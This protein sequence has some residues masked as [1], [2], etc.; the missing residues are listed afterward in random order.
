[1]AGLR[2]LRSRVVDASAEVRRRRRVPTLLVWCMS[3]TAYYLALALICHAILSTVWVE[4][5]VHDSSSG[6]LLHL[7]QDRGGPEE[8]LRGGPAERQSPVRSTTGQHRKPSAVVRGRQASSS[9]AED[10]G[11]HAKK[12]PSRVAFVVTLTSCSGH[13]GI[14]FEIVE[15]AA[16]LRYSIQQNV[17]HGDF[18]MY[19]FYH[20]EAAPCAEA[21]TEL[22]YVVQERDTPVAV[23]DIRGDILRE[24]I[25]KNGCCGEKELIK[26][27][28]FTL[29]Q[30]EVVVLLDL[31]VL[32]MK[33]MDKLFDF[34][35]DPK[36]TPDA[37]DLLLRS[38][39]QI[40][41]TID[42][43]YTTDY[44]MVKPGRKV[45][46]TQGG[47]VVLRPNRTVYDEFVEIIVEGDFRDSNGAGWGGKTGKFWGAMTFQ[48]LMPYYFQV[49]HPGRAV[50]LNW[51]VWNNMCS[52]SRDKGVENDQP[53]GECFTQQE[54]CEDC[55]NR[56][57]TDVALTHFTVC[58]KPW[59]CQRMSQDIINHRL[60]RHLHHA[61]FE[62]R[63][64]MERS[65]GR[66]GSGNGTYDRDHFN[67][68]CSLWG[69]QGYEAIKKPYGLPLSVA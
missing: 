59:T 5:Q 4:R 31:D 8:T 9:G 10:G 60:C 67:G 3:R 25:V 15:G 58:Q 18:T 62:T 26:L 27:E 53:V 63:S 49:L 52:P 23:E 51:C 24:R 28:A 37:D 41:E 29:T 64:A 35:L 30:H 33:S 68:Y 69:K 44:A 47:F 57:V 39:E 21:L 19:A 7:V 65:W 45:K 2:L 48:G 6:G 61:W 46:P 50:E 20:P 40:P 12:Q 14:P 11:D 43:L 34:I 54:D 42:L 16:V 55:R 66:S 36:K 17:R 32:V 38:G 1:M 22:G 56:P 13:K